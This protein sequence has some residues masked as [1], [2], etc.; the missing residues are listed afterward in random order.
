MTNYLATFGLMSL[1]VADYIGIIFWLMRTA[2][3]PFHTIR[4]SMRS[5]FIATTLAAIHFSMF[6]ALLSEL[7][8]HNR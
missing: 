1:L 3:I 6:A 5:L 2:D 4:F 7:S 8:R